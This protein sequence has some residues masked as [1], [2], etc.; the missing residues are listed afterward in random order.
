MNESAG[1]E[2]LWTQPGEILRVVALGVLLGLGVLVAW[3]IAMMYREMGVFMFDAHAY[4]LTGQP[5]DV[6]YELGP[7]QADAFLYS[8]AF[9]QVIRP[10]T[11]LPWPA[12]AAVWFTLELAAF[13]WLA[14]P[15][16]WAWG[17]VLLVWCVPELMVGNI[18]A[19]LAVATVLALSGTPQAWALALLTKPVLGVGMAYHVVRREWRALALATAAT[20]AIVAVSF[21]L[22]PGGWLSWI[23]FLQGLAG[24]D[25]V[26]YLRY[27]LVASLIIVVI[28]GARGRAWPVPVALLVALPVLGGISAFTILAAIPR[29]VLVGASE[30]LR[31]RGRWRAAG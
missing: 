9:A 13:V 10:L 3:S 5:G 4:W 11:L 18:Y 17:G 30:G 2:H 1:G 22:D 14:K 31:V 12:F 16:G 26:G 25:A 21:A 23:G 20:S 15:L 8:P 19:F 27:R 7:G 28:A 29:L 24:G 6:P